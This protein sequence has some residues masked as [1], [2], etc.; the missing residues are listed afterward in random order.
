MG[1]CHEE[2]MLKFF[3]LYESNMPAIS[4][5]NGEIV[6][7]EIRGRLTRLGRIC[8]FLRLIR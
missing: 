1:F 7:Y 3:T 8:R 6:M 5:G 2:I 4:N